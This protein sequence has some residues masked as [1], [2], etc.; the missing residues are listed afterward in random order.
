[1]RPL[2]IGLPLFALLLTGCSVSIGSSDELNVDKGRREIERFIQRKNHVR[3]RVTC[4]AHVK[5]QKG[6]RYR[7]YAHLAVGVVPV[8]VTQRDDNGNV[9][10]DVADRHLVPIGRLKRFIA[11]GIRA[12]NPD[13]TDPKIPVVVRC[14]A[15]VV[16][17]RG[18]SFTCRAT[19]AGTP[20]VVDVD[21]TDSVGGVHFRL[22]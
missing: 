5:A 14:P 21:Q 6:G 10:I 2:R 20:R 11:D 9:H 8:L 3:A 7:C 19:L 12:Q 13:L 15:T 17:Q 4:P 18:L 22:R 16:E 1:M